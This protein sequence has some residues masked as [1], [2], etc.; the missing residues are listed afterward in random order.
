MKST[1]EK[2]DSQKKNK[3]I[4]KNRKPI[5]NIAIIV[6]AILTLGVL[7]IGIVVIFDKTFLASFEW[8]LIFLFFVMAYNNTVI[9]KRKRMTYIYFLAGLVT[10]FSRISELIK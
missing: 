10:L 1:K 5:E 2:L 7:I 8:L 9:Y 4:Q 3:N 6:Q